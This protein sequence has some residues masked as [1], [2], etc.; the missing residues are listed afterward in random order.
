M[1]MSVDTSH[2]CYSSETCWA[3]TLNYVSDS[4]SIFS[5]SV[6]I[7][8]TSPST[9]AFNHNAPSTST[10]LSASEQKYE[11]T[12]SASSSNDYQCTKLRI[13]TSSSVPMDQTYDISLGTN[14]V[15]TMPSYSLNPSTAFGT[16]AY[17]D[18]SPDAV[19]SFNPSTLTYD[20]STIST[21]GLYTLTMV[22]SSMC[23]DS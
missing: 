16:I 4:T 11:L 1:K 10:I 23:L 14:T 12:L 6:A 15:Y 3:F 7:E 13:D 8:N 18:K 9:I 2:P 19:I 21:V 22:G 20:W 5:L 17:N